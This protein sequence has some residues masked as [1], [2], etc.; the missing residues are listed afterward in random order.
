MVNDK[1]R[2]VVPHHKAPIDKILVAKRSKGDYVL[3]MKM[4]VYLL[5]DT[6]C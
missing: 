1:I 5:N 2:E 4:E 3:E 6:D